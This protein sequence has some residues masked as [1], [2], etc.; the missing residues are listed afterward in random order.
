MDISLAL[1]GGGVKGIAHIGVIRCLE[2]SGL[3]IR[4]VAGT[5]AGAI[6]GALYAA[7]S[8]PDRIQ[9][10]LGKIETSRLFSR[11]PQDGPALMGMAG[12]IHTMTGVLDECTFA[13]LKIPFACTAV[14]IKTAQ[15]VILFRGQ[16]LEAVLASSAVPGVFPPQHMDH[17]QLVDGGVL[18][19]VPVN[20]A[21]WL[22]PDLPVVAVVLSP[23]PETWASLPG[24]QFPRPRSI[25][26]SIVDHVSRLRLAQAFHIFV[27]SVDISAR[28]LTELR[29]QVDRPEV[30]IRPDV[31]RFGFLDN[32]DPD[33]MVTLGEEA[34]KKCIPEIR[35]MLS[36]PQRL[37]RRFRRSELPDQWIPMK[38]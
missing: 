20:L 13:D 28:M 29:L 33:V 32:V 10:L 30:V 22:A 7:G 27:D 8:D 15:E 4:A 36:W 5:S 14:D 17:H 23:E 34:A 26:M 1:G 19:P 3:R 11:L 6:I 38:G 35:R 37:A 9:A 25:P 18:D 24:F 12:V 2:Q 16:V 21:R 31:S